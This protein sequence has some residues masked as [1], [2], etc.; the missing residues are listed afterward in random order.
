[1]RCGGLVRAKPEPQ[2]FGRAVAMQWDQLKDTVK[3][4]IR[5]GRGKLRGVRDGIDQN[6]H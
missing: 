2:A 5:Q 3:A 4:K 1:M 6:R